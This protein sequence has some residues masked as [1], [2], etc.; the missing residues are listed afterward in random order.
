M[1]DISAKIGYKQNMKVKELK[2]KG[3]LKIRGSGWG[4][5]QGRLGI[6]GLSPTHGFYSLYSKGYYKPKHK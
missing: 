2:C 1:W 4:S 5:T 6:L 3:I